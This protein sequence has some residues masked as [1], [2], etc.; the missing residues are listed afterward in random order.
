MLAQECRRNLL[1]A[2]FFDSTSHL[3][4][5]ARFIRFFHDVI[6][7][8]VALSSPIKFEKSGAFGARGSGK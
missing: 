8:G 2:N 4:T 5:Q 3:L 7:G 1:P 6:F